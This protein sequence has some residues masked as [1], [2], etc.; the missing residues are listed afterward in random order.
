MRFDHPNTSLLFTVMLLVLI[1]GTVSSPMPTALSAGIG[2]GLAVFGVASLVL[3]I[4]HG[5]YRAT[6][7]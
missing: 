1:G 6:G 5:E 4:E 7:C 2:V 3:G